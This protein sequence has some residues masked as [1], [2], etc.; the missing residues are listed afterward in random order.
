MKVLGIDIGTTSICA[1]VLDGTTGEVLQ[2]ISTENDA[3]I[4]TG[5]PWE[6]VQDPAKILEKVQKNASQL[7]KAHA[8]VGG[9]GLTGQMHG[10]LYLD[11]DG[12]AI[13]P[14]YTW[15]DGRGDLAF[16]G[17]KTYCEYLAEAT[18]CSLATGFGMATHFY[19]LRNGLVPQNAA[20][21]CTIQDYAAMKLAGERRPLMH[22]SDAA[23]LGLFDLEKACFDLGAVKAGGMD[24]CLL[25][26]VV[27]GFETAGLYEGRIPVM[28]AI[29]D[30]QAS[31]IGAVRDMKR[32]ILVNV[33]TGSQISIFLDTYARA[34]SMETRPLTGDSFLL[35]GSSLCGG[36]AYA[37]LESFFR[38]CVQMAGFEPGRLYPA[39]D[40]LAEGF[41]TLE[42]KLAIRTLFSGTRENPALRGAVENLG[43][44]NFT[45]RHFVVGVL[46]GIVN[47]LYEKYAALALPAGRAPSVLV[48]S[49]N[50][51]R[52]SAVLQ[53]MFS[54]RFQ[55]PMCIPR[56]QEEAA[57]GAARFA[58]A[59]AGFC[60]GLEEA[61][62]NIQ[63][64]DGKGQ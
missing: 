50:G 22:V 59:G 20:V 4:Q 45:P 61:Q 37:L 8:P 6:K 10:I 12:D 49:G 58:L 5:N 57:C 52:N 19:N 47:E 26:R 13:S 46:E 53:K 44:N 25:P 28:A 62:E 42:D 15:Q 34:P 16:K 30:N 51:I 9:I 33:G 41:E 27:K 38:A 43:I 48:G 31:F 40:R 32:S 23:S 39:M 17:K 7:L 36:R 3:A 56:Y 21:F 55:M 35:V 29:G 18:G 1:A 63:Y 11:R 24:P 54:Q 60:R 2:C 64:M 14:L